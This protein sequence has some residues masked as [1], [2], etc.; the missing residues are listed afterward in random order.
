MLLAK[1]TPIST[2]PST[3]W[4][5]SD[6]V[7]HQGSLRGA[8]FNAEAETMNTE[9]GTPID[10]QE[11]L[12]RLRQT[13]DPAN[14]YYAAWWLGHERS[15]HPETIP[16]LRSA[17]RD[18]LNAKG[19]ANAESRALALNVLRA[20]V[21]LDGQQA[22]PEI[23]E[24]LLHSDLNIREEAARTA[25]ST[26]LKAAI[27]LIL[28][29][30]Q[31][32][33]TKQDRLLEAQ[34]EALGDL[35]VSSGE[36]LE[37]LKNFIDDQRPLIRSATSR[38]LLQLTEQAIYGDS[39]AGLLEHASTQIR[40][41]VLLD[42]GACGWIPALDLIRRSPVESSIKLIALRGLAEH[43]RG[44]QHA[45]MS[46]EQALETVLSAMDSLL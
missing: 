23:L 11:A 10:E 22:G 8:F 36:I 40:R 33:E 32:N 30:L 18:Y 9:Q 29:S 46:H 3:H 37:R 34:L 45:E 19:D 6:A 27:P 2:T 5:D 20:L 28:A 15:Q 26:G 44:L 35:G 42:I 38:A 17:L 1:P 24:S 16:L 41:G 4:S 25:G 12:H 14:R 39:F 43:P 21:H 7:M 13:D 31:G